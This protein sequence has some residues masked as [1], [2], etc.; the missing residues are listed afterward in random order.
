MSE[1]STP[2]GTA[3]NAAAGTAAGIGIVLRPGEYLAVLGP[4]GAGLSTVCMSACGIDPEPH[5]EPSAGQGFTDGPGQA[6][7]RHPAWG[8]PV[9]VPAGQAAML[10][11]DPEA[12]LTGMTSLVR[13][14]VQLPLRLHGGAKPRRRAAA[15]CERLGITELWDR[16]LDTLSGGQ[17]QLTALAGL[18]TLEPVTLVLDQPSLSLDRVGRARLARILREHCTR[19]GSVLVTGHQ[20]DEVTAAAGRTLFLEAGRITGEVSGRPTDVLLADHG[21]WSMLEADVAGPAQAADF[22]PTGPLGPSGGD[23]NA[24]QAEPLLRIEDLTVSR[25]THTILDQVGLSLGA[26]QVLALEGPNGIGKSTLLRALAGILDTGARVSGHILFS[27]S[28]LDLAQLPAHLRAAHLAWV[29][30][31][32]SAQLSTASVHAELVRATPLPRLPRKQRAEARAQR[33]QQA[34]QVAE[35]IG[36]ADQMDVHPH[37]LGPAQRK[38]L[39]IG[40][41]LMLGARIL[42]LDEPTLGRDRAGIIALTALVE[43]FSAAG[44]AVILTTHDHRWA[45]TVSSHRVDLGAV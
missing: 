1:P 13:D 35:R 36:L 29:G 21:V 17:R 2:S 27:P 6:V 22:S 7:A 33:V 40:T 16:R 43:E 37:D 18:L 45:A 44:G 25:G 42:L 41:A 15:Q 31:D 9:G 5:Q 24:A 19:G 12:Q 4:R 11:D 34:E 39:V 3:P 10:G 14:E 26:G 28:R 32:P 8:I 20:H 23:A 38:D 30:Q